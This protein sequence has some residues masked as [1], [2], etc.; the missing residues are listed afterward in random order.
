MADI[1][2]I[3]MD[4]GI[5]DIGPYEIKVLVSADEMEA[6]IIL[7]VSC[8]NE[9]K[10]QKF[11]KDDIYHVLNQ[12]G[13]VSGIMDNVIDDIIDN[14]I[15][16]K[17]IVVA[18]GS[19]TK[20]GTDGYY[21]YM[22][23]SVLDRKPKIRDDG[24][25]D[26]WSIHLVE[27]VRK[28]QVIAKYHDPIEG[29]DGVNVYGKTVYAKRGKGLSPLAGT[30]FIRCDNNHIYVSNTDGKIEYSDKRVIILPVYEVFGDVD[31]KTGNINFRGDVIVHGSVRSGMEIHTTG[32]LTIDGVVEASILS[33]DKDILIR[34][35][36]QG[37][38]KAEVKAKGCLTSGFIEYATVVSEGK[39]I[40]DSIINSQ[41]TC[42]DSVLV[43]HKSAH[44]VGGKVYATAGV[45]VNI[46][47]SKNNVKTQI[48]VGKSK[49]ILHEIYTLQ[50]S[51]TDAK[52]MIA[53]IEA[54]LT[55]LEEKAGSQSDAEK[56]KIKMELL[57]TKVTK[58]AEISKNSVR[59]NYLSELIEKG[60]DAKVRVNSEIYAG[61]EVSINNVS[62]VLSRHL[63]GVEFIES[64]KNLRMYALDLEAK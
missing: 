39:L 53:K 56:T 24:T 44:I 3:K 29:S 7:P 11:S 19:Q 25:A 43:N 10:Q 17:K 4:L 38:Y 37:G 15:Y 41:V 47:G 64:N 27:I 63:E 35:G 34:G 33:S 61:A 60:E 22:F 59:Y 12:K 26:Y 49:E 57:R 14:E 32:S 55:S 1:N 31:L 50:T 48:V 58:Q 6:S 28:R 54:L 51:L 18:K 9:G 13:V 2:D 8:D 21:E 62:T 36:I 42:Y 5:K 16:G 45:E 20:D 40:A 52:A 23:D 46:L 30:G